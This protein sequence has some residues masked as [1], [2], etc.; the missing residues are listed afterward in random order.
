MT[1]QTRSQKHWG[2]VASTAH[3][4]LLIITA[5]LLLLLIGTLVANRA[6]L[7]GNTVGSFEIDGNLIVDHSVP[8]TEPIDWD[9]SPFPAAL[10]T[11]TDGTGPTDDIFG[12]GSKENDQ[13][14]WVCTAGSAPPKD[15]VVNQ[16]SINSG[17][18]IAGE[19]AFRFFPVSGVQKQFLYANWS[20]LPASPRCSQLPRRTSGDLLISFDTQNGGATI[21]VSAFM[22]SG[23]TFL[24]LSVG[25]QGV[26][27]DAAVNTAPSITGLTATGTN[28]FGE[29]ALNVSDTIG[30]IPCNKVL[31]ASMKTR[32]STSLSAELKDRTRVQPL[33]FTVFNPAG[34]NASGNALG[35]RIQDTLLGINQTLPAATPATCTQG[36]CSSQSGIGST[37][38]SNQVLNVAV[39]PPGGSVLRANVLRASSTS[40][41][42][43]TT[44]TATDTGVAESAG[45]NLVSGLVTADVVRGVATAQAS[46]FNSSFSAAGSA[47]KNLVVNGTQMNNVNPNTT[48]DL[49]AAQFGA[50]SFVKLLEEIG[51]S[52]QPPPGQLA[53]GTFAADLTVNM[54]RV[55]ISS[56]APT[57]DAVDVV[58]S[59]AQAHADFPQP[60]GCPAL[61]GTVSG[62]ATIVNEQTN[63][64]QLPVVVGFVSIPPQGGH[65]HQDLDQ[66]STSS[67][68]GGTS[69]SDSAGTVLTSS[70]NSSSFAKAQNVC[71]LPVNGVCT[72]SA[73]AII[74]QA[75]SASGGGKSSSDAQGTTL[76]GL[77]VGG[78]TVGDNPP[79]NTTILV[80]G[81]GSVTL[82]EQT[83]DGG[84]VPPCSGTASSGIR[85]RAI[86]VIVDNPNAT[87][88]PQGA[89]VI[90]GEAHADSS[91]P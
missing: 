71:V 59:H 17:P 27:W 42:D 89:Q 32:A 52:S 21:T 74:S 46:G 31:F 11:F 22:W 79:P 75:N 86:H 55:H 84:G 39:P 64:S 67:V 23:T 30:T 60:A 51:S 77:S 6:T 72:V 5:F 14:S 47:F 38:N 15:D 66:L 37:S 9:S 50:G 70:S 44:N 16:I 45:V 13:S 12:M 76:L 24:P 36:V 65:D 81:I 19:I 85:V 41:V 68:S 87:G 25:S 90:V 48:I 78:M 40:T 69:V 28:L 4:P 10:T 18:P 3:R 7:A 62:D 33:N 88:V 61:V 57:G 54:I 82:N 73:T 43:P 91:H 35:A 1:T 58:V 26:L 2:V 20:R 49:P 34:A 56:L 83:C 29:L 80:S 53:G 63:P 8:P